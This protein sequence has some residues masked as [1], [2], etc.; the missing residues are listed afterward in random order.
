[1]ES[2][3]QRKESFLTK[4]ISFLK[5]D[6]KRLTVSANRLRGWIEGGFDKQVSSE[7]DL[8]EEW[9][10]TRQ[11]RKSFKN[12]ISM[13]FDE[14][15]KYEL[16]EIRDT[17]SEDLKGVEGRLDG[18]FADFKARLTSDLELVYENLKISYFTHLF[19]TK[20]E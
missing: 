9:K 2:E 19:F 20:G 12:E 16:C 4:A 7:R 6:E 1:M 11:L 18:F 17:I 14:Q 13:T 15:K 5:Q 10:S 8:R 3:C